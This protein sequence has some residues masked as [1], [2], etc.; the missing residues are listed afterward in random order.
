M[1]PERRSSLLTSYLRQELQLTLTFQ[2]AVLNITLQSKF[3]WVKVLSFVND[4]TISHFL[5]VQLN[6]NR[7]TDKS[8]FFSDT[9][10]VTV[11]GPHMVSAFHKDRTG[12]AQFDLQLKPNINN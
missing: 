3:I 1:R 7:Q 10:L 2:R 12:N 11:T 9:Q 6:I 4:Y 5:L 8:Q